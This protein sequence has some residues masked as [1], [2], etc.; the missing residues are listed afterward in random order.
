[1]STVAYQL[2]DRPAALLVDV[3]NATAGWRV[4]GHDVPV[5]AVIGIAPQPELDALV[6]RAIAEVR[7]QAA[8]SGPPRSELL[9]RLAAEIWRDYRFAVDG[10]GEQQALPGV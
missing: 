4:N 8:S 1:V 10:G 5:R 9:R 2:G 6:R 7:V 3:A